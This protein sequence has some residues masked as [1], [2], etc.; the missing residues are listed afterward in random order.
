MGILRK[1]NRTIF[2]CK[3]CI[4]VDLILKHNQKGHDVGRVKIYLFIQLTWSD[5]VTSHE[6]LS[7]P[8]TLRQE[9]ANIH[10]L[11]GHINVNK[12]VFYRIK[13]CF[14]RKLSMYNCDQL[15]V[16]CRSLYI[17]NFLKTQCLILIILILRH[18]VCFRRYILL[19]K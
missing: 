15:W 10:I 14:F 9:I 8:L 1:K 19:K 2:N 3:H 5:S 6:E 12:G 13:H 4:A 18:R 11:I 17:H 7:W 16:N